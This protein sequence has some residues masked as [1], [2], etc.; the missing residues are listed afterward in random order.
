MGLVNACM[1]F[2][3]TSLR[4]VRLMYGFELELSEAECL[5]E[6]LIAFSEFISI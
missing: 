5:A 1:P 3:K 4:E 6:F 2:V